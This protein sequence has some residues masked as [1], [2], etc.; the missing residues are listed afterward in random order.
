MEMFKKNKGRINNE[1]QDFERRLKKKKLKSEK[2]WKERRHIKFIKRKKSKLKLRKNKKG[3]DSN[4]GN[5]K[6]NVKL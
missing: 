6:K 3:C 2:E 5:K 4:K 1:N